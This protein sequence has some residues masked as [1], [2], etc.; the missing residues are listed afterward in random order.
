MDV[1][2]GGGEHLGVVG[3]R[4]GGKAMQFCLNKK[5]FKRKQ[6]GRT[7]VENSTKISQKI[8]NKSTV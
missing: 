4:E 5:H 7:T 8:K 1:V 3:G 2:G 6:I